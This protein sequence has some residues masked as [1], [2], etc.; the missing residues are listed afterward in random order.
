MVLSFVAV[1]ILSCSVLIF[2]SIGT[3]LGN[4][5][6]RGPMSRGID[7]G[8]VV[9]FVFWLVGLGLNLAITLGM[10]ALGIALILN[11]FLLLFRNAG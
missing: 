8:G 6:A 3:R 11:L 4:L 10:T 2:I 9:G 7:R 1:W 5:A